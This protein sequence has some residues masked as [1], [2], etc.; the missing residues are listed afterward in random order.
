MQALNICALGDPTK[1]KTWSGTPYN[2]YT[3]LTKRRLCGQAFDARVSGPWERVLAGI[4][5]MLYGKIDTGRAP[6]R[7]YARALHVKAKT[8][9]APSPYTLHMGTLSL[10]FPKGPASQKHYL[11]CDSTWNLWSRYAT[12]LPRYS[13]R[14]HAMY[15]KLERTS[16]AQMHHIFSISEYVKQNL[17]EHYGVPAEKITVVGTGL[18][19]IQ[20]FQGRKVYE[21]K[22]IL[23]TAKGRFRD[24]GGHLVIKAFERALANR[25]QSQTH[26]RRK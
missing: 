11:L 3:E 14:T 6:L 16:Y 20:P 1:R 7:R 26:D 15:D 21:S 12:D 2:I 9:Q 25:P 5:S 17:V 23:F 18:G 4:S 8:K 10:P 13:D 24:K 22:K 19:A